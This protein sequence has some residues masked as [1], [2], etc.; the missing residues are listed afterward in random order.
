LVCQLCHLNPQ[1]RQGR[2]KRHSGYPLRLQMLQQDCTRKDHTRTA[3]S[4]EARHCFSTQRLQ[5][6]LENEFSMEG[7]EEEAKSQVHFV[8][9]CVVLVQLRSPLLPHPA[10]LQGELL[11]Q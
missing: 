5:F 8:V 2:W 6:S 1:M 3:A 4:E 7:V 11:Q 10:V 9:P